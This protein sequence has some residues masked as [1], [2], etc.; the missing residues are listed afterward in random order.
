MKVRCKKERTQMKT[1]KEDK[2]RLLRRILVSYNDFKQAV[3]ISSRI[4]E[5]KFH[6]DYPEKD[7]HI[8]QALNCAMLIAYAR[9]FSGNRG[10][11]MMLPALPERFLAGFAPDERA[12]HKVV[13]KD[14]NEV[15]AHSDHS[16]WH[17][18]LSVIT[19]SGRPMLVPLHHDV[20]AP[21][22]EK[23]T[24]MFNEMAHKLMEAV[25]AERCVLEKE[26][27][28]ALPKLSPED[29]RVTGDEL[30]MRY[31]GWL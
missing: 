27:L 30:A 16:A 1:A 10:S 3:G 14:R 12:L 24:R 20:R 2:V 6:R 22:D 15:L 29:G 7:R 13:M 11:K 31:G 9:P 21:L 25:F 4:L 17:L 23:H 18:R 5:T 26:L 28:D 19:S 8:L